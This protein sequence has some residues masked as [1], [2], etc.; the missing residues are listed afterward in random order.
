MLFFDVEEIHDKKSLTDKE[1]EDKW[2]KL[3]T[4]FCENLHL[5]IMSC[6]ELATKMNSRKHHIKPKHIQAYLLKFGLHYTLETIV[7]STYLV[8][9]VIRFQVPLHHMTTIGNVE[10]LLAQCTGSLDTEI[11]LRLTTITGNI[12]KFVYLREVDFYKRMLDHISSETPSSKNKSEKEI[13][14]DIRLLLPPAIIYSCAKF[15]HI[16]QRL[17]DDL[18]SKE[19]DT[20]IGPINFMPL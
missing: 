16:N 13:F 12:V 6:I 18:L 20:G 10:L 19:N 11:S 7:R 5:R 9:K 4:G 1:W 2:D 3:S 15:M 17:C 8:F 14:G